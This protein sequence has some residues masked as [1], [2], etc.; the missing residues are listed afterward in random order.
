MA[1][2]QDADEVGEETALKAPKR[3]VVEDKNPTILV[4]GIVRDNVSGAP[5]AGVRVNVLN[6]QRY[7]AMTDA[8]G[9][10]TIKVPTFA[11]LLY[12]QAPK[13]QSQQVAIRANDTTQEVNVSML[14]DVF[15]PMYDEG[16]GITAKNS[17]TAS[18]NG[19]SIDGEIQSNLGADVRSVMRSGNLDQGAFMQIRGINSLN[20]NTQPLIIID[21]VELDMQRGRY[22]LHQGDFFNVLST[23]SPEDIDKVTVLKNATALYGARGANGVILIETKRGHSFATRI[24]AK[25]SSGVTLMPQ[26]PTMMDANQYRN[27]AVEQLGTIS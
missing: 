18:G 9:K 8:N 24:D 11:T 7:V 5:V 17:F 15:A 25:I 14:S 26:L 23:L 1:F 19:V 22:S 27:Y 12:V 4:R 10:F 20:A 2:A 21:G 16:T 13:Y 6:D 3:K